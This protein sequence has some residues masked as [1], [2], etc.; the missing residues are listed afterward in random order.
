MKKSAVLFFFAVAA[1]RL[2][3]RDVTVTVIDADLDMPLEGAKIRVTADGTEYECDKSGRAVVTVPDGKPAIIQA[4]YPG[5]QSARMAIPAEG[6]SFRLEMRL[7]GVLE[8]K[9]LVIEARKPAESESRVGRSITISGSEI[10]Q[11]A[12]IGIVE[13]VMTA[14]KLL[15]G[16]GFTGMFS[17]FPSIRGGD[18]GDLTASLDGF[19]I[20]SPYHWGGAYSIFDPS[21]TA[22]ARL[23]HGVFSARYGHTISGLLEITAKKPSPTE[24][25]FDLGISS[26]I[27][28]F[29][30]SYPL[31]G[32]GGVLL[33][34]KITYWDPF[35]WLAKQFVDVVNYVTVAPYIRDFA[36][37]ANYRVADDLELRTA[38]F[39]GSDGA[40]A[41]WDNSTESSKNDMEGS[42]LNMTGYALAGVSWNPTNSMLV[43]SSL[44][45][46]F[47]RQELDGYMRMNAPHITHSSNFVLKYPLLLPFL[48]TSLTTEFSDKYTITDADAQWRGE[49]DW[50]LGR[51]FVFASGVEERYRW[52][53]VDEEAKIWAERFVPDITGYLAPGPIPPGPIPGFVHFPITS[54]THTNNGALTTSAYALVEYTSPQK[55]LGAELGAR[56]DHLYYLGDDQNIQTLPAINPRF[57]IDWT[58][59]KNEW[60]I[61]TLTLTAGTGLFSS[62]TDS[63]FYIKRDNNVKDFELKQN[64]A[65]TS[66]VG[67]KIDF[68]HGWTFTLEGYYKYV[69]DRSYYFIDAPLPQGVAQGSS[70]MQATF[71][72]NGEGHVWG[73]DAMLQKLSS[74]WFDGWITYSFNWARYRNPDGV[75]RNAGDI[76]ADWYWPSFHRFHSLNLVLN[77][78]PVETFTIYVRLGFASGTPSNEVGQIISYPVVLPDGKVLEKFK[79]TS[80]Y[81]DTKRTPFALPLDIKLSWR[82][83]GRG[84]TM[85]E[86]YLA[87]ENALWWVNTGARNTT[88]NEYTGRE[89][90][91]SLNANY[92]LPIPMIS[93]GV[94]WSF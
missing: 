38:A 27:T 91:G 47:F 78:K 92:G 49:F 33:M 22:S 86:W 18:P 69:F 63:L 1:I 15:P 7:G 93:F 82:A 72:F 56:L 40:A 59:L 54:S 89:E 65:W 71:H 42:W 35:V 24:V 11:S 75:K 20:A 19:Y 31:F 84:K 36:L 51:G 2:F 77:I 68:E 64:R 10:T 88:Y 80:V 58:A 37:N 13:D 85:T 55:I 76:G 79:R 29:N 43:T 62:L 32:K 52:H 90:E 66:I 39:F 34:G 28:N 6:N 60:I 57:N 3:A 25:T 50:D 23:S 73:I 12:Q 83:A 61:D 30:L 26:A 48:A 45:A 41:F 16:V 14:I 5:Y 21:M 53:I 87:V 70:V 46:G 94:K 74:R 81:S 67:T 9:E 44:G 4:A 17:A 8:G